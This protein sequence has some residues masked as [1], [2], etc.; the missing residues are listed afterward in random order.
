MKRG[1]KLFY[2]W[3]IVAGGFVLN[4][5]GVGI[6]INAIPVFLKPVVTD[7]QFNRGDFSLYFTIVALTMTFGAPLAGKLLEKY[8]VRIVMGAS[9]LLLAAGFAAYSLCTTLTEFYIVSFFVGVGHA[10]SHII[11]VSMLIT[12]WFSKK[13]GLAMGV[14]FTASGLGGLFFSPV[15]NHIITEYGWRN[16]YLALGLL[17]GVFCV[18]CA[19][20]VMR[21]SPAEV[22]E[23]PDGAKAD[24]SATA[25][26]EEK[27]FSVGQAVKSP[28]FWLLVVMIFLI[29]AQAMGIQQHLPAYLT[30]RGRSAS[31]AANLLGF[32]L[33]MIAVGK[34]ILGYVSDRFGSGTGFAIFTCILGVSL[35]FLFNTEELW[36]LALFA[37]AF[38]FGNAVITVSL[39]LMTAACFGMKNFGVIFGLLTIANALGAAVGTPGVGY[40]YDTTGSYN[41]AIWI[42][43][44]ITFVALA[45]GMLAMRFTARTGMGAKA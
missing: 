4:F 9:T 19:A 42:S 26:V 22:G 32:Y 14:V 16:G 7:L 17:I 45:A 11:P 36:S 25:V 13:R 39:P 31:F 1:N 3:W 23:L 43:I 10:G 5:L 29:D 37:I 15:A 41:T 18:P 33:G 28:V 30:D 27:G 35:A 21:K 8:N 34:I 20:F 12:N 2:G 38:G 44:A 6:G 24:A 40:L